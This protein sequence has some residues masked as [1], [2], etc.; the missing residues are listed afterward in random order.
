MS[1][2]LLILSVLVGALFVLIAKPKNKMYTQLLLAFSGS[3]LLSVTVLHL[4][5]EVY[6]NDHGHSHA[7]EHGQ[8][9]IIGI[10]ILVGILIQSVLESFSKGAEH[11][12]VHI[13]SDS[14]K[15]A[16]L[17]FISLCLHAFSEGLPIHDTDQK[18][19]WAIIVHKVPIAIVLTSFFIL[20]KYSKRNAF[21]F[22]FIFSL[23]S[24]L[25]YYLGNNV[26]W[27]IKNHHEITALTIGIF[28][29]ISTVILFES[30][31]NHRFD[32]KKFVVVVLGILLTLF[33][34]H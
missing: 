25:G 7:H 9:N 29:H 8:H 1:Y 11:G 30:S 23:M 33:T 28:L 13:H 18:L 14:R 27:F 16:W 15:S 6:S 3:Y 5:P 19:L 21:I 20:S 12:H 24:P 22:L 17:L 31:E 2:I 26:T 34:I 32:I 10:L 4:L